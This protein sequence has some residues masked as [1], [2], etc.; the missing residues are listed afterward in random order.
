M[1]EGHPTASLELTYDAK[2]GLYGGVGV[3]GVADAGPHFL[4]AEAYLGYVHRLPSGPSLDLGVTHWVYSEYYRGEGGAQFSEAYVGLITRRFATHLYYSPSYFGSHLSTLYGE[5]DSAVQLAPRW[6]LTGHVGLLGI[7]AGPLPA[8]ISNVQYDARL[9]VSRAIGAF[10]AEFAL[11]TAGP[12]PDF[13]E[14]RTRGR[15]GVM[16]RISR[17]F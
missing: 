6:R 17:R 8:G 11:T 13:Y 16:F 10:D 9:G 14:G 7:T 4:S 2:S 5:V 15:Q 12:D 1:S 3:R